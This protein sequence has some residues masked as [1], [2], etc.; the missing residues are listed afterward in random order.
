VYQALLS[1]RKLASYEVH[2]RFYEIGSP[3]G[4]RETIDLLSRA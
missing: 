3:E 4:L 1:A 2:E